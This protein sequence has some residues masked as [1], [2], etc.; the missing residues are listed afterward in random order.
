MKK[1]KMTGRMWQ[2]LFA[3]L[4]AG[5]V[6]CE[7]KQD[8]VNDKP[9]PDTLVVEK[10]TFQVPALEKLVFYEI[11]LRSFGP[12][13]NLKEVE[14][15]LDSIQALGANVIWLM[16]I[17]PIGEINRVGEL[18]SPYS[19]KD[20][21]DVNPEFGTLNDLKSL[22]KAAH[23]KNIA[24]VLDWVANHTAW[25]NPWISNTDWY[26]QD[27]NGNI[28]SPPG[29]NWAD[30]ADLNYNN[31]QMRLEMIKAM[32]F[33]IVQ[34]NIDGFR[35]DAAD[36]VPYSFWRQAIDSLNKMGKKLILLAEGARTDHYSAGFQLTY[37]WDYYGKLLSIF[38]KN[39]SASNL[40]TTHTAEYNSVPAGKHKLRFITNHDEYA[41]TA[42][43]V[44]Q[45]G[46][47]E[48]SLA[49]FVVTA[50]M[51]KVPLIYAGQEMAVPNTIPFFSVYPLNWDMNYA[52]KMQYRQIMQ[53]RKAMHVSEKNM[54]PLTPD[55]KVIAFKL[56]D[57]AGIKDSSLLVFVNCRNV[58]VS[59][60]VPA[61]VPHAVKNLL[62]GST[63]ELPAQL[64]LKPFEYKLY[65]Y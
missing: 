13:C 57:P 35:C 51:S 7:D 10:D 14:K 63:E 44:T 53:I 60:P 24:V 3:V 20:Y 58:Q 65:A 54:L 59:Y 25:D 41:W 62:T 48:G 19:V 23:K 33:W 61:D 55:S 34:A 31:A 45:Y 42:S 64:S 32:K 22:V 26:T 17:Y 56:V 18:G 2:L 6:A 12:G 29:T 4:F 52:I 38:G 40:F 28:I 1:N 21:T 16:P 43:P 15:Q 50:F 47:K 30:V 37:A 49:A 27:A 36:F 46:G 11:N 8:P 39:E 5:F 9:K